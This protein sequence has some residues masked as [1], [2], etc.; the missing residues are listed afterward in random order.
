[1]CSNKTLFFSLAGV[2]ATNKNK[3]SILKPGVFRRNIMTSL[4]HWAIKHISKL[5]DLMHSLWKICRNKEK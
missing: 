1:M 2:A 3:A 4:R 5:A